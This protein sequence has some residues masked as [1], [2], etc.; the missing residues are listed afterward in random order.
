MKKERYKKVFIYKSS[1]IWKFLIIDKITQIEFLYSRLVQMW[2]FKIDVKVDLTSPLV[3]ILYTSCWMTV[4]M[5]SDSSGYSRPKVNM[6][7][8]KP[9]NPVEALLHNHNLSWNDIYDFSILEILCPTSTK[10]GWQCLPN[11]SW[12]CVL[13]LITDKTFDS[14][15]NIKKIMFSL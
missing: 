2:F 5:F 14:S 15:C 6:N 7:L 13:L 8:N 11:L 4:Q 12:C 10:N 9:S 1:M 3:S